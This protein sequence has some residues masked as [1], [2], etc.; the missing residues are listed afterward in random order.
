MKKSYKLLSLLLVVVMVFALMGTA[1]AE[2]TNV[3]I[4]AKPTGEMAGQIVILHTNDVHGAVDGYA[5]IAALKADYEAKGAYV[6]LMDAGDYSQG[7]VYV[8]VSKGA[9]AVDLM[10]AAKYDVATLGNHEFDYGYAQLAANLKNAKFAVVAANVMYNG[11]TAFKDN[12]VFTAPDGTKI[13]VFGLDTP[14]TA[15]KANPKMIQ[16]VTFGDDAGLVATATAQ[17]K[18]LK[19]AGCKYIVCLGHLGVDAES[20]GHQSVDVLAKVTG[21][22]LFIDGHSHSVID[23]NTNSLVAA[24]GTKTALKAGS[25]MMV[26][27]GTAF[28][29]IGVVT[30]KD[31]KMTASLVPVTADMAADAAVKAASDAIVTKIDAEYGAKFAVT[32]VDLDGVKADVRSKETNMGDLITDALVWKAEKEGVDVDAALTNGGGIR[33]A[34]KAGDITKKDINTVMPFGN[35]LAIVKVTGAELLEALEASTFC[36]PTTVGGFPQ[37][38]GINFTIDTA[39]AFDAGDNYPGSTYAAPKTINRVSIQSVGGKAFSMTDTYTIVTNNF[40]AGGGDTYYAFAASPINYDLGIPMDEAVMEYIT[41]ALNGVVGAQYSASAG[42]ITIKCATCS[43]FSDVAHGSW[44]ETYV[45][46]C[47]DNKLMD[48]T[49]PT[50]FEPMTNMTRGMFVTMLYRLAGSPEVKANTTFTDVKTGAYYANAVAWA[51]EKGI[52]KGITDTTF[53]PNKLMSREQMASFIYRYYNAPAVTGELSYTDAS[54]VSAWAVDAV[55]YCS[56]NKLMTG[57]TG[58]TFSAAGNASRAMGAAVLARMYQ[59]AQTPAPAGK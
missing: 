38:S 8:S 28:A 6:L 59:A 15:T 45:G 54:A 18:A 19:D 2:D 30:I 9:S 36:T 50:T 55:N 42:R 20:V 3:V 57:T 25:T 31:G 52:T 4:A 23:G 12:S 41:T 51:V 33:A 26:S 14:E 35:T 53:E 22:D 58:T 24:D 46:V 34:I 56:A 48:G 16:G 11:K 32:K 29:N 5:K 27:T 21:I 47:R 49:T 10:N 37:V 44:Y 40:S 17:V 13:G 7:S 1:M 39:K 43:T